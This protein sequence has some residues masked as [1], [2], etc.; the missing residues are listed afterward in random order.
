MH[1]VLTHEQADFDAVA[2]ALG[3]SLRNP[4]ALTV[5]PRRLN[6]NVRAYLT[7]YGDDLPFIDLDDLPRQ[8][9]DEITLVDTQTLASLKRLSPSLKVHV[10]DHHPRMPGLD[11]KW[12][13]TIDDVGATT[14]IL[15]ETLQEAGQKPD[16]V[17]A[18]LLLLG[19][20]EDTGSLSYVG[21]RAR[22]VRACAW[23]LESGASLAVAADF[24]NHPL[25]ADQRRLYDRLLEGSE[26]HEV[27][28]LSII[29]AGAA[30]EGMDDEISTLAHKL[31]DLFDPEGL[32]VLVDLDGR[33]Q[34]VARSTTDALD[35]ARVA[36]HFGGGGHG[37]AAAALIRGRSRQAVR[38][39]LL[40]LLPS[41]VRP[42]TTV[43]EIMSRD[44]QLLTRDVPISEALQ[45]MQR[46]GHEG[47]PVVDEGRVVGLL[48]RRAV[49]RAIAHGMSNEH[50]GTIM[51]AGSL[52]VSPDDSIQHLQ[53]MMIQFDW[54]QVP[55]MD[56]AT[57]L[58][59][60]IVTRTDLIK[61]LGSERATAD[62]GRLVDKLEHAL[63]PSR[64]RLLRLVASAAEE[65]KDA[66]YVVGG[67]VRDLILGAPGTDF[68]LVVEGNAIGLARLLVDRYG[69]RVSSHSRFRTAKWRLDPSDSRLI[70]ALQVN[71]SVSTDIPATLDFVSARTEFY[72]HPTALPSVEPGSIKL[73]LHRRDFTINTMAL[74]LDGPHYG[75]LIDHWGGGR[76]LDEGKIR[77][78]HSLSFVDD[79]T[80]MLRAVRLEQRLGFAIEERT[81]E[82]MHQALPLLDRVSGER[83]RNE[84]DLIFS[85]PRSAATMARLQDLGLLKAIHPSVSWDEWLADRFYAVSVFEPPEA[86]RLHGPP[87]RDLL[88]YALL[89]IRLV[90]E[91]ASGVLNRLH[92]P[93]GRRDVVLEANRVVR[94]SGR[95]T[96]REAPSL[97]SAM[98]DKIHEMAIVAAWLAATDRPELQTRLATYLSEWRW[99]SPAVDGLVLRDLGLAPGPIYGEILGRLRDAWLDGEI[100]SD[101]DEQA[102][103]RQLMEEAESSG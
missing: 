40:A 31:R 21:T 94:R 76:D 7:L 18:T 20:Y 58:I 26:M 15:V 5:L 69:G 60:G 41:I 19:I 62:E 85:E 52:V 79:P 4:P 35:V 72:A 87:D 38:D 8:E 59:V 63:S 97:I 3:V 11:P 89:L 50:V 23:L 48:T 13:V 39:E 17:A 56:P 47:Y 54:G 81:L 67:F 51:D 2:S 86:W 45:R 55:V 71:G 88:R 9:I 102:L 64:L 74:R 98:L 90:A 83:I 80:R 93:A 14:T 91:E 82:L 84:L 53:R 24:L 44:P 33:V 57:G 12:T 77:V 30:A 61:T 49:D 99:I 43:E 46:F 96:G 100:R 101:D 32:F 73:D 36:E 103:L 29:V 95:W 16:S 28:G 65:H 92:F 75:Q 37:R 27:E 22:D 78:L 6:R 10:I 25:S 1:L 70:E 68:D 34:L 42:A 66:L